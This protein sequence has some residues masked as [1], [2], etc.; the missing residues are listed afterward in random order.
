MRR[1]ARICLLTIALLSLVGFAR[2]MVQIAT[3]PFIRPMVQRTA[4]EFAAAVDRAMV[5]TAT[6]EAIRLRLNAL[7]DE[8]PR[9]WIAIQ[10]VQDIAFGR[11]IAL[12]PDLI[13]RRATLWD[14]D[15]GW[16]AVSGNCVKCIWD[17]TTCSLTNALVCNTPVNISPIGDVVGISKAGIA[18][19]AG[20]DV[21]IL[22][23]ALSVL[24]AASTATILVSGGS[25]SATKAG[26]TLIKTARGMR[27]LSPRLT[28]LLLNVAR[29]AIKWDELV[30]WDSLAAPTRLVRLDEIKPLA[31]VIDDLGRINSKLDTTQTLHL[32]RHIDGPEDARR[33]AET[34]EITGPRVVGSLELIGKAQ[35]MRLGLRLS[36][37]TLELMTF[38]ISLTTSIALLVGSMMQSMILRGIK[39][40]LEELVRRA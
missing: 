25:S 18:Y 38:W 34:A 6:P 39:H 29:R 17:V 20:D 4:Q 27:L 31:S 3:D 7:L 14:A 1:L 16:L 26:A 21:D 30:H 12:P 40:G 10:A 5:T 36:N 23:L 8:L 11:G 33:I 13:Q 32:L 24:G 22:D 28:V 15:S 9:N 2:S 37:L 35:F 19:A